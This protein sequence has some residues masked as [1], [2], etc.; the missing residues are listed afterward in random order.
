MLVFAAFMP[1]SPL[2]F[3]SLNKT[4]ISLVEGT[5]AA[6][7]ELEEELYAVRPDTIVILAESVT[8]YPEAFSLNVADP[9]VTDLSELGDLGYQKNYHPDFSFVDRLQRYAR[10]NNLPVSLST[11]DKLSYAT[12]VPLHYLTEHLPDIRIVPITPSQ[13]DLKS[14]YTFGTALKHLVLES[15]KRV[16]V[17]AAADTSHALTNDAPGGYHEDSEIFEEKLKA[18]IESRS[19]SALL[20]LDPALIEN[21]QDTSVRQLAILFGVLDGMHASPHTLSY[22]KPFGVGEMVVNFVL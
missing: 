7:K 3:P 6:L 10:Q 13:L 8:M 22:E 21:A 15:D 2:L 14:H 12:T 1:N 19:A 5:L 16:A 20:Q 18:V 4:S 17:I 11:D 9:Y